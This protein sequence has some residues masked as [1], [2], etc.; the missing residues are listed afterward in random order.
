[1]SQIGTIDCGYL[2]TIQGMMDAL[3]TDPMQNVDLIADV[4]SARAVLANQRVNMSELLG[5]KKRTLSLEWLTKCDIT[6]TYCSDDCD[7][8]GEDVTPECKEYEIECL[9][10]TS[11]QVSDRVYRERTIERSTAIARNMLLHMNAMDEWVAQY[12][13]AGILSEAG[14]NQ[15][16]GS[17]GNVVGNSTL[18]A[19]Q[20]W[21]DN[22]WGYLNRV[23]RANKFRNPYMITGDNL[24]EL[25]FNRRLEQANDNGK[26]G[27]A[28]IGTIGQIW[29]DPENVEVVAP[30]TSFLIHQTAVAF[31][32]KAWNPLGMMNAERKAATYLLWSEES[33]NIPG[34]FYDVVLQESCADNDFHEAYKIQLHGLFAANPY[35][36]ND[37][38]T[39]VLTFECGVPNP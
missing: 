27:F 11:F 3:W 28:K 5:R 35:P 37:E 34:V 31:L 19:P 17:I 38:Q 10:E 21:N 26:G 7:I 2:A 39:G 1:M 13:L 29:Q 25:L 8:S 22:I 23:I 4:E 6:T 18:I 16:T 36:C 24:F 15:F 30:S 12:I 9:R 14:V 33:R 20:N 32:S